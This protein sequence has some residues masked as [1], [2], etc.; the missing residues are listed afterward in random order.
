[1]KQTR[2]TASESYAANATRIAEQIKQI[3]RALKAHRH[4]AT[5]DDRNWGYTADLGMIR[6]RLGDILDSLTGTPEGSN[7]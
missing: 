5:A 3:E 4:S 7:R 1:M 6:E 2:I